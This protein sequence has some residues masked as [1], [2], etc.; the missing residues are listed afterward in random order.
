MYV[1]KIKTLPDRLLAFASASC[2]DILVYTYIYRIIYVFHQFGLEYSCGA[3]ENCIHTFNGIY[4]QRSRITYHCWTYSVSRAIPTDK[5]IYGRAH[6]NSRFSVRVLILM[7]I[8]KSYAVNVV[9]VYNE[10]LRMEIENVQQKNYHYLC[11][12]KSER[13]NRWIFQIKISS[14]LSENK[15]PAINVVEC[16]ANFIGHLWR[17]IH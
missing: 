15:I 13:K 17:I 12:V 10:N 4:E 6:P 1:T 11:S 7:K 8:T 2:Y 9:N 16:H 14:L 3:V 5:V